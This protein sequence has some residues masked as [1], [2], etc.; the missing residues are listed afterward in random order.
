MM[1][2]KGDR[3]L[4]ADKYFAQSNRKNSG[5]AQSSEYWDEDLQDMRVLVIYDDETET[6]KTLFETLRLITPLEELL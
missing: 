3:V 6:M 5:T 1:F 2:K 4:Y